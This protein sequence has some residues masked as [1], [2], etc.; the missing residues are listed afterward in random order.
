MHHF[1]PES[2]HNIFRADG[3]TRPLTRLPEEHSGQMATHEK[4]A[5]AQHAMQHLPS[6]PVA[7]APVRTPSKKM[8]H[9]LQGTPQHSWELHREIASQAGGHLPGLFWPKLPSGLKPSPALDDIASAHTPHEAS[10]LLTV[11]HAMSGDQSDLA[12]TMHDVMAA[13]DRHGTRLGIPL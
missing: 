12:K 3:R 10:R 4:I 8:F 6:T 1:I 5:T 11:H 2:A 13:A 7:P 9:R